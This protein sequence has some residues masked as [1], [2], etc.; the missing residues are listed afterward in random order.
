MQ[1]NLV[2]PPEVEG[3]IQGYEKAESPFT[4]LDVQQALSQTRQ[5][6]QNP[7]EAESFGAWAEILAFT[8][9]GHRAGT[10]PWGTFFSPMSSGTDKDGKR[11]H[12]PDITVANADVVVHWAERA[13]SIKSPVLR[14]RYADLVWDMAT[15]IAGTPREPDMARAAIDSYLAS[16]PSSGSPKLHNR[17][18]AVLRALDLACLIGD[19]GRTASAR[20]LLMELHRE[21]VKAREGLWW[22]AYD[23]L[24]KDKNANTTDKQRQELVDSLEKLILHFGDNSAPKKFNPHAVQDA[25]TRLIRHYTRHR[26]YDDAKRLHA[27]VARSFEHFASLAAALLASSVLQIAVN[28]YRDAG[29]P[30][31]SKRVRILMQEKIGQSCEQMV[32]VTTEFKVPRE[33]M[34]KFCASVIADD[35]G[36]AFGRL[37]AEFLPNKRE[38]EEQV[39]Q[40]ME[41]TPLMALISQDI[42]ADDR[43]VAKIGSVEGDPHGRLLQQTKMC[44]SLSNIWLECALS[45]LFETH[46]VVPEHFASW[47]NRLGI[48]EDMTFLLEGVRAWYD[49]DFVKAL[50]VLVPQA[51][52]GLRG[53]VGQLGKPVTKAHPTVT[54]ASVTLTMGDILYSE[55]LT[56]AL[57]PDLTLYFRALYADPRGRNLR[58]EVAHGLIKCDEVSEHL[59][60]LLIHTL[61]VFGVWKELAEKRR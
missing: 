41:Q 30:E 38:L 51:E 7:T 31:D 24:I 1:S 13:K 33:D 54:G 18:E 32:P 23:R 25:A 45:K 49:G 26:Q 56:E 11:I 46:S 5:E 8:L 40:T 36:T 57:G 37:A 59:V 55:E 48:F 9:V 4:V 3:V 44:F 34:D 50:H 6:L 60:R 29:M 39:R 14:A 12:S 27:V 20:E 58:N 47:A 16:L 28:A 42:V 2:I 10:S 35:L 21:A 53:I 17:F 61:L 22:L 52:N 19:E 43:V 15:V